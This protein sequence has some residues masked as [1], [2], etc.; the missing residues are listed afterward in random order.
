MLIRRRALTAAS[1]EANEFARAVFALTN[2]AEDLAIVAKQK[3]LVVQTTAPFAAEA[4]PQEFTAPE[5]FATARVRPDSAF[6]SEAL[7]EF[8]LPYDAVRTAADPD[9]ALLDFLQSTYEAAAD[10]GKWDRA[11][12]ECSLGQPRSPRRL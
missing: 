3:G 9:A 2:G 8:I 4:D 10:A 6:F 5:G 1:V 12:L 7:G 11:S